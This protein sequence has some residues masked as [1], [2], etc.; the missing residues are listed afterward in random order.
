MH[1]VPLFRGA[2]SQDEEDQEGAGWALEHGACFTEPSCSNAGYPQSLH[3]QCFPLPPALAPGSPDSANRGLAGII[4]FYFNHLK[5]LWYVTI[6]NEEKELH[7]L[8]SGNI[9]RGGQILIPSCWI[10]IPRAQ[11]QFW[12]YS[13]SHALSP[14]SHTHIHTVTQLKTLLFTYLCTPS[15]AYTHSFTHTH[16]H[17]HTRDLTAAAPGCS[18]PVRGRVGSNIKEVHV[19]LGAGGGERGMQCS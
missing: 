19:H 17:T 15:H 18:G 6:R 11:A 1:Y 12:V 16:T 4:A 9:P 10:R 13:H 2:H 14:H 7:A 8:E 3:L 5:R